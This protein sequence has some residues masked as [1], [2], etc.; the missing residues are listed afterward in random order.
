MLEGTE[1]SLLLWTQIAAIGQVFGAIAT[2][3]AVAVSLWIVTSERRVKLNISAGMRMSIPGDGTPAIDVIAVRIENVG[4]RV[5]RC[6]GLGWKTGWLLKW[7][8]T[9]ARQ[10]LAVLPIPAY[11]VGSARLPFD[12][13]P[14]TEQMIV[15]SAKQ[16]AESDQQRNLDFSGRK[17]PWR[18]DVAPTRIQLLLT[19]AAFPTRVKTIEPSLAHFLT[20]GE[21][22]SG[23]VNFNKK[24]NL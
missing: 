8:P 2:F 5:V 9:W 23:A 13:Q 11:E 18:A 6:V 12:L 4:L 10:Q 24:A 15:L 1:T 19:L 20:Y 7:G 16:Y 22:Q 17:L 21:V 14:G 3:G